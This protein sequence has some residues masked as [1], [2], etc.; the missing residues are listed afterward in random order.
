M[1]S[2][3]FFTTAPNSN[4]STSRKISSPARSLID[5]IHRMA[6]LRPLNLG[7]NSFSGNI[8]ASIEKLTELRSLQLFACQFNSSFPPEIGNLSNLER[9]ELAYMTTI[10]PARFPS[11]FTELKK[12]KY[13]WVAGSNLVGEILDTIGEMVALEHL[14]LSR[15]NLSGKIP[16]DL[17]LLKNLRIMYLYKNKFSDEIPRVVEALNIDVFLS[18]RE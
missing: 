8:P 12:L 13:L 6:Q 4:T 11:E 18:L 9:L 1:S 7:A 2:H 17:F 3:D 15:N 16:S 14:D 10:M 5:D